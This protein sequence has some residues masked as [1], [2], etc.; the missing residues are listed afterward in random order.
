MLF[1]T[2]SG[3]KLKKDLG[4]VRVSKSYHNKQKSGSGNFGFVMIF[5]T[6]KPKPHDE[7]WFRLS[8]VYDSGGKI[9]SLG[10]GRYSSAGSRGIETF[11]YTELV[12]YIK[13]HR[14][15]LV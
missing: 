9:V 15:R 11:T 1:E 3:T 10:F 6:D 13:Q 7:A 12:S 14:D 2:L 4:A 8:G 5:K